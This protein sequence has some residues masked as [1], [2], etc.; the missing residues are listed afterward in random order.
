MLLAEPTVVAATESLSHLR[1]IASER[2]LDLGNGNLTIEAIVRE[3]MKPDLKEWLDLH[4]PEIVERVVRKE[5]AHIMDRL[6][7]K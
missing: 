4:L 6:D 7:L 5:V 2:Q 1:D 3:T